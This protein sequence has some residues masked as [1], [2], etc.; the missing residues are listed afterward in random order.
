MRSLW[1]VHK[2]WFIFFFFLGPSSNMWWNLEE[3]IS[4]LHRC[5]R[6]L[7][8][9]YSPVLSLVFSAVWWWERR[10]RHVRWKQDLGVYKVCRYYQTLAEVFQRI[11]TSS[12]CKVERKES[13]LCCWRVVS[14]LAL[15]Q[16]WPQEGSLLPSLGVLGAGC[17]FRW[18]YCYSEGAEVH[19]NCL[20]MVD[21]DVALCGPVDESVLCTL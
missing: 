6:C 13:G 10:T 21:G 3:C 19:H 15:C 11:S 7:T 2:P 1:L 12:A 20:N 5:Y 16:L 4:D 17:H 14:S 9:L 18:W 8:I